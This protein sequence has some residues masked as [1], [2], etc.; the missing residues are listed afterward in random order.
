MST[1]RRN[2]ILAI[3]LLFSLFLWVELGIVLTQPRVH[4]G[5]RIM[6]T[7]MRD[8]VVTGGDMHLEAISRHPFEFATKEGSSFFAVTE[9]LPQLGRP[10]YK[11]LYQGK[12]VPGVYLNEGTRYLVDFSITSSSMVMVAE[13]LTVSEMVL[14]WTLSLLVILMVWMTVMYAFGVAF[15]TP[16]SSL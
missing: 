16:T 11:F 7:A 13:I 8:L 14:A 12:V 15:H 6:F 1:A 3:S 4:Y 2:W 10:S 5:E 9:E